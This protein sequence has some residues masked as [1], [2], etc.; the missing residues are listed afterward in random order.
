MERIKNL[1]NSD[2]R[3]DGSDCASKV[4]YFLAISVAVMLLTVGLAVYGRMC[5]WHGVGPWHNW[6]EFIPVAAMSYGSLFLLATAVV[7]LRVKHAHAVAWARRARELDSL[8]AKFT[9]RQDQEYEAL[10]SRLHD[11]VGALLAAAKFETEAALSHPGIDPAVRQRTL[12]ALGRAIGEVRSLSA[13]VFPRMIAQ[14]GLHAG[15]DEIAGRLRAGGLVVDLK[16]D[17]AVERVT[18]NVAL[19][20]AR[21]VQEALVNSRRHG[22][23]TRVLIRLTY[24][25]GRVEGSVEDNGSGWPDPVGDGVG[26][27]LLRERLRRLGGSLLTEDAP[28]GGARLGFE[29]PVDGMEKELCN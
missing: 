25:A 4:G 19:L 18:G 22:A 1:L 8:V 11:D 20:L 14:F 7:E 27:S 17:P 12:E 3:F 13:I 24:R 21:A 23:A 2:A 28:S 10:S 5:H 6:M 15:L 16:I 29:V 9:V 26:L